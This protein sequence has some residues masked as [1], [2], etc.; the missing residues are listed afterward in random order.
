MNTLE[1]LSLYR[2]KRDLH[3]YALFSLFLLKNI[4]G[5]Y[6]LEIAKLCERLLVML[7]GTNQ[8]HFE[9]LTHSKFIYLFI[10]T[11]NVA[12]I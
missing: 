10:L 1:N 3:V 5:V 7:L 12:V 8:Y 11:Y 2:E 6:S 4:D 9:S